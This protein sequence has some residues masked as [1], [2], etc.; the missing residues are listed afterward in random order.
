ML[1]RSDV[2]PI[3]YQSTPFV[4]VYLLESSSSRYYF[5]SLAC[6]PFDDDDDDAAAADGDELGDVDDKNYLYET[7][8]GDRSEPQAGHRPRI[9][10]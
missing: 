10:R 1:Q 9:N 3:I 5:C 8:S 4:F 6:S 2:T 7:L